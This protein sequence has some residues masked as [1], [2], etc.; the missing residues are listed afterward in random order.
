MRVPAA[1]VG[2]SN[3]ATATANV[4]AESVEASVIAMLEED[5]RRIGL[6]EHLTLFSAQLPTQ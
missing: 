3:Y 4:Y 2:H 5:D 6:M 1:V